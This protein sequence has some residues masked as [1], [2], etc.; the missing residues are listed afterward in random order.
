MGFALGICQNHP[1]YIAHPAWCENVSS[2]PHWTLDGKSFKK[3]MNATK[4]KMG[5]DL[6]EGF[7]QSEK[8]ALA[9]IDQNI[10]DLL[11]NPH[12]IRVKKE[13]ISEAAYELLMLPINEVLHYLKMPMFIYC[14]HQSFFREELSKFGAP[15]T[16][17]ILRSMEDEN[18]D[19]VKEQ[20]IQ[21]EPA[22]QELIEALATRA[23]DLWQSAKN[24]ATQEITKYW[25]TP[26]VQLCFEF[27]FEHYPESFLK[28]QAALEGRFFSL[29]EIPRD[30][31]PTIQPPSYLEKIHR[32]LHAFQTQTED[33]LAKTL[34]E[35][36]NAKQRADHFQNGVVPLIKIS[37]IVR[38][39]ALWPQ[40]YELSSP[41]IHYLCI[42][43]R[44]LFCIGPITP[45]DQPWIPF[46]YISIPKED[47]KKALAALKNPKSTHPDRRKALRLLLH[48]AIP[49]K[50]MQTLANF[51]NPHGG[52][53]QE[54][55]KK[56][57]HLVE[58]ALTDIVPE[59]RTVLKAIERLLDFEA[60][61]Y[62]P[63][64][65]QPLSPPPALSGDCYAHLH[66]LASCADIQYTMN[67]TKEEL[68]RWENI[69][70]LSSD[71]RTPKVI[72]AILRTV[73][74]LGE[75]TKTFNRQGLLSS[76]DF[77]WQDLEALRDVLSHPERWATYKKLKDISVDPS[78]INCSALISDFKALSAYYK[79]HAQ[80]L[81][82]SESWDQRK[83]ILH[84][85]PAYLV[86]PGITSLC[87]CFSGIIPGR[88]SKETRSKLQDTVFTD[89][90][91][92]KRA[93]IGSVKAQFLAGTLERNSLEKAI[94]DLPLNPTNK[95]KLR[96]AKIFLLASPEE[97]IKRG[98]KIEDLET[99]L[100]SKQQ[101]CLD[102]LQ[103]IDLE[104]DEERL[105]TKCDDLIRKIQYRPL[106][107]K[108]LL[109]ELE[110]LGVFGQAQELWKVVDAEKKKAFI[111]QTLPTALPN[112]NKQAHE[113]IA[114]IQ[115]NLSQL[116]SFMRLYPE[117]KAVDSFIRDPLLQLSC[118]Y[119]V[120]V[121]RKAASRLDIYLGSFSVPGN[122]TPIKDLQYTL[123]SLINKG[124]SILHARRIIQPPLTLTPVGHKFTLYMD[125][126]SYVTN[127]D[128]ASLQS[129]LS[130]LKAL[131]PN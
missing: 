107:T 108:V 16:E 72:F 75:V 84:P 105:R 13:K 40:K 17:E 78:Q 92:N 118:E 57:L 63:P 106:E 114:T 38:N 2:D 66:L 46:K 86:T 51:L 115:D 128:V 45:G 9:K 43:F 126:I 119:I 49:W 19:A 110:K 50:E 74:I 130:Q 67:Q 131:I 68:S 52:L 36:L 102:I 69:P 113:A 37:E 116:E 33:A 99:Y 70:L 26:S 120:S 21:R 97:R 100:Q 12:L 123:T 71:F 112:L 129:Q 48:A 98:G 104:L 80:L 42:N 44:A 109:L 124:N 20:L 59:M 58:S 101:L 117:M 32:L 89:A 4:L 79:E 18:T 25:E 87:D 35:Y 94:A 14:T 62:A 96:E 5:L 31:S 90:A 81:A 83:L 54:A 6:E 39:A 11:K 41:E 55:V 1:Y 91:K 93:V 61:E 65:D 22:H 15:F 7:D 23:N 111:Q 73:Q 88:I 10:Q 29:S 30:P 76:E 122:S 60:S 47:Q 127:S 103:T 28:F 24:Q 125:L 53:P 8:E 34:Q 27:V 77:I 64:P 3:R 85:K 95:K 82:Q 56:N 121:F